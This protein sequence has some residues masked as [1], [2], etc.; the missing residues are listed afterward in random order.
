LLPAEVETCFA[1]RLN[2]IASSLSDFVA[3]EAGFGG[4]PEAHPV[5]HA[6]PVASKR[7]PDP[8]PHAHIAFYWGVTAVVRCL[9]PSH[10]GRGEYSRSVL[11]SD[12]PLSL[13]EDG[14]EPL[15]GGASAVNRRAAEHQGKRRDADKVA[16]L[17]QPCCARRARVPGQRGTPAPRPNT[18]KLHA[19]S[20]QAAP[21]ASH[22]W[23]RLAL[24]VGSPSRRL[25]PGRLQTSRAASRARIPR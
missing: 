12:V 22:A 3:A 17:R 19:A 1:V 21:C 18:A 4:P 13:R 10:A 20:E 9:H 25:Q 16:A 5:S 8:T 11:L 7:P 14:R 2:V 6:H 15:G 24:S 23:N